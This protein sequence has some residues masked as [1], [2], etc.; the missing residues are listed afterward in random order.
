[1]DL[2]SFSIPGRCQSQQVLYYSG[3]HTVLTEGHLQLQ[4]L[5]FIRHVGLD[6]CAHLLARPLLDSVESLVDIHFGGRL[7]SE[8]DCGWGSLCMQGFSWRE[9]C[10]GPWVLL[11]SARQFV[12]CVLVVVLIVVKEL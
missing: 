6:V 1:V 2:C 7:W 5:E 9:V 3:G 10:R 11:E 8:R 4:R 12:D